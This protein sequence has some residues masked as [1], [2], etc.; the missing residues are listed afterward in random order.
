MDEA[1]HEDEHPDR[2]AHVSNTCPHAEHGSGMVIC[3]QGR[4][5]FSLCQDNEG[6]E[7]LI[8]LAQVKK[9]SIKGQ[10][11]KPESTKVS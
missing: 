3:L 6:I 1:V 7:N 4:A 8:E 2:R 5:S 9:P 11:F 10:S